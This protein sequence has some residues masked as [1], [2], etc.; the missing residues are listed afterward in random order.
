MKKKFLTIAC[1]ATLLSISTTAYSAEGLY[2][3]GNIGAAILSDSDVTNTKPAGNNGSL[4]YDTGVALG[5]AVGYDYGN[6]IRAEIEIEY[7][8]ND[9]STFDP[10]GAGAVNSTGDV[11]STAFLAN[12][13]YD[14]TSESAFT[15]FVT[16][17]L[18]FASLSANDLNIS[19]IKVNDDQTVFAYQLGFGVSYAVNKRV[20]VDVKYRY[21]ATSDAD[22]N[23]ATAEYKTNN[24]TI[25]V[26]VGF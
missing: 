8:K 1:C 18:G 14:F 17:G 6:D 3:S 25:G 22:F 9:T 15:P 13:Y 12:G 21:F 19:G 11:S 7:Q 2:V 24:V 4:E 23:N 20:D 5:V 10:S 16:G 26:K